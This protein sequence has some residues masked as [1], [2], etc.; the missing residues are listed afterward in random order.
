MARPIGS[1]NRIKNTNNVKA[2]N[3]NKNIANS[4]IID[5]GTPYNWVTYGKRNDYPT[6][7]LQL[8]HNSIIHH[9]CVDFIANAIC[10]EGIDYIQSKLDT[11]DYQMPNYNDTWE[12]F[13]YKLAL[14]YVLFGAFSFQI[15]KNK[16]NRTYSYYHQPFSTVRFGKKNE[17]GEIKKAYICKDWSNYVQNQPI[18]LDII[19]FTDDDKLVMCKQYLF[20]YTEYNVFDD[21][22]ASPS[23][24]SAIDAIRS[25]V[26]MQVYDLNSIYNNFTPSGIITLNQVA[27]EDE[28]KLILQNIESTFTNSE[29]ANNIIIAFRNNNNDKPI[30]YT[31]IS[32]NVDGVN[33]FTDTN[34]RIIDR[35]VTAH[36][37][38]SKAL[39]GIPQDNTGFSNEGSLLEVSYNLLEKT[40]VSPMRRKLL[41][42][43]NRI[44]GLNG[45]DTNIIIIPLSF[46]LSNLPNN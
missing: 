43:I 15:I 27:D 28:R 5:D 42:I 25:D 8:Y 46:N 6:Q 44:F 32:A 3:L 39:I 9:S 14:D 30:E 35:I 29:N 2:I 31:P 38:P 41:S 37:I 7:L 33:L 13:I 24:V 19:N 17:N 34:N 21:Y 26:S 1:K 16:D 4:P 12:N 11:V 10:G 36:R 23:Y 20:V 18:E 45:I 40:V 22:Y